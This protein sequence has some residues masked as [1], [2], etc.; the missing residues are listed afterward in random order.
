M[1]SPPF[2]ITTR[3]LELVS[4]ISRI[5]GRLEGLRATNPQPQLRR[6]NRIR[7]IQGSLSIEGN[8]LSVDQITAVLDGKPVI[9]ERFELLEVKNAFRAY[10]IANQFAYH[11]EN[12]LLRAHKLMM[13]DL[14]ID[15]GRWRR[16]S[17]GIIKDQKVTHVAPKSSL[18]PKLMGGLFQ[19][20]KNAKEVPL[21]V[22]ACVFHYE[23]ES[24]HPFADGNGRMGRF[25][26]HVIL[27]SHS[28]LFSFLPVESLIKVRQ[29]QYYASLRSSD[30]AGECSAFLEF[31]L[32]ALRDGLIEFE[33]VLCPETDSALDRLSRG[34]DH[35]HDKHFSRKD[36]R[37]FHKIISA[38]TASRDLALAV[39]HGLLVRSGDKSLSR[40]RRVRKK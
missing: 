16:G 3:V 17:V 19:F 30:K 23:L 15:A 31:S 27:C 13:Q 35:F 20:V 29:S 40:Y 26:Q 25:W 14:T 9:G 5:V 37:N 33:E 39:E 8:T 1:S 10:E 21:I 28:Q 6:Q 12:D 11:K 4:E 24:I 18:I 38:P 36:Y 2:K 32:C 34:I 22:R 7:T